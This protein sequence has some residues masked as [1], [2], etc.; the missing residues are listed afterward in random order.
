[1]PPPVRALMGRRMPTPTPT[2]SEQAWKGRRTGMPRLHMAVLMKKKRVSWPLRRRR[3]RLLQRE[4]SP[5]LPACEICLIKA[6]TVHR[7]EPIKFPVSSHTIN[8]STAESCAVSITDQNVTNARIG[9]LLLLCGDSTRNCSDISFL[10][11][12]KIKSST[13]AKVGMYANVSQDEDLVFSYLIIQIELEKYMAE[14]AEPDA[15][16]I[17]AAAIDDAVFTKEVGNMKRN[18]AQEHGPKP[19]HTEEDHKA[20]DNEQ[21]F[22]ADEALMVNEDHKD[23]DVHV[24]YESSEKPANNIESS[25]PAI[26]V[27]EMKNAKLDKLEVNPKI[28][29]NSNQESS[30]PRE[31]SDAAINVW[32]KGG[33]ELRSWGKH[34]DLSESWQVNRGGSSGQN[35]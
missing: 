33:S 28:S 27:A 12:V 19:S 35:G 21:P 9:F 20:G 30:S 22:Q 13:S 18:S 4:R 10:I 11:Q 2:Q 3:S 26:S 15:K 32:R 7:Q 8:S 29:K 24:K 25:N 23:S 1:M 5:V 6:W 16:S 31:L 17:H 34:A 14:V